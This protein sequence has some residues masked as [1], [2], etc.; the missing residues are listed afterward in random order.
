MQLIYTIEAF[1]EETLAQKSDDKAKSRIAW[2][3]KLIKG[4]ATEG[5]EAMPE[6]SSSNS[7]VINSAIR[8]A[9]ENEGMQFFIDYNLKTLD[10][11]R[12]LFYYIVGTTGTI[13]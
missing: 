10:F 9:Q 12:G 3:Y 5:T 8:N 13:G 6:H 11:Y 4:N 2:L 1:K 7:S